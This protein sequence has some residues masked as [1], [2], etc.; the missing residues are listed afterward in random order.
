MILFLMSAWALDR[1]E[2]ADTLALGSTT[3]A[4]PYAT[5]GITGNPAI[6]GTE[7]RYNFGGAF[8]YGGRGVHWQATAIDSVTSSVAFGMA[9][10]GDR[11]NPPLTQAELPGWSVAG[12]EISN[13]K[14]TNTVNFALGIPT[15][16]RRFVGGIGGALSFFNNERGGKGTT[17]N[18]TAGL[19]YRPDPRVSIGLT[20][21]NLLP[22]ADPRQ[23]RP[24]EVLGGV[25]LGELGIAAFSVDGGA[26]IDSSKPLLLATGLELSPSATSALRT[27]WR[28]DEGIN[29]IS[30][31]AGAGNPDGS[32]DIGI[33]APT[34]RLTQPIDWTFQLSLRF[35]APDI[36][37]VR[38]E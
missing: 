18:L 38:P 32:I 19:A 35:K 7:K 20:G 37:D 15:T 30:L 24:L 34:N 1:V 5:G 28:Y 27:G 29:Y 21:R 17:G 16:D 36:N 14:Q 31:G 22:I 26:R 33:Q 3:T 9:Y 11:F 25:W 4:N 2:G 6:I 12:Q 13:L 23:E 8:S 10:S